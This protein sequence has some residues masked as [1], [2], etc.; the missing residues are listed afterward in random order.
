VGGRSDDVLEVAG[1]LADGWNGWGGSAKRFAQD[2]ATVVELAGDRPVELSW[3]SLVMLGADDDAA[4]EKMG[5]RDRKGWVVGG[6]ET[7]TAHME[8]MV[9]A[10]ARHMIATFPDPWRPGVYE[11]LAEIKARLG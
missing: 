1:T 10:G 4:V 3:A 8:R 5:D 6:P 11:G 9:E 7:V 2:A